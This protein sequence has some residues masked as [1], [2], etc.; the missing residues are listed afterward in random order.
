MTVEEARAAGLALAA[1]ITTLVQAFEE[2]TGCIV[3]SLPVHPDVAP[4]KTTVEVKVQV[5]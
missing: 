4:A 3:H 5:G 2:Q 1:S